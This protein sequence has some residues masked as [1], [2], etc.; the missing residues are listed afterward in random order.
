M[1]E[2]LYEEH[3]ADDTPLEINVPKSLLS[4]ARSE[5]SYMIDA[6]EFD[7]VRR[8]GG[9]DANDS[10]RSSSTTFNIHIY[11]YA[12]INPLLTVQN[13]LFD[14]MYQDC[15]VRFV[16]AQLMS[17]TQLTLRMSPKLVKSF[18]G[19]ADCYCLSDPTLRDNPVVFASDGFVSVTG[20]SR[21]EIIPYNCR[22]LQGENTDRETVARIKKACDKNEEIVEL[23]LNYRKDKTPFWN[24]LFIDGK[25]RYFLGAQVD[26]TSHIAS[27]LACTAF[28]D[29]FADSTTTPSPLQ[30]APST[31][32]TFSPT[33]AT[34]LTS[35]SPRSAI[36]PVAGSGGPGG[37]CGG[38]DVV[39]KMK[40]FL[41]K[42]MGSSGSFTNI[43]EKDAGAAEPTEVKSAKKDVRDRSHP[44]FQ[45]FSKYLILDPKNSTI[46]FAS[47]QLVESLKIPH[48]NHSHHIINRDFTSYLIGP[49][50]KS[51]TRD[52]V[53][54][55]LR[56]GRAVAETIVSNGEVTGGTPMA[57]RIHITP[58]KDANNKV[59]FFVVVMAVD[60][61]GTKILKRYGSL[62]YEKQTL[63]DDRPWS[64]AE[65][66][67]VWTKEYDRS[68]ERTGSS[69]GSGFLG[70]L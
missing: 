29:V 28:S 11:H 45:T 26:V 6:L 51:S 33:S 30:K 61:E 9:D 21:E 24:L 53:C 35:E 43:I 1:Y 15:F 70:N 55:A 67:A 37:N 19:L 12:G 25:V 27:E 16:K 40:R 7:K 56:E 36:A 46:L 20:Y 69:L 65:I 39:R 63:D 14:F 59:G 54:S 60:E 18:L 57:I 8:G 13:E 17:S 22:F 2:D 44:F 3:I 64:T 42:T 38:G 50:S 58:M 48:S 68:A 52:A 34:T 10:K 4:N 31:I 49:L 41:G 5:I 23:L 62:G 47:K 66:R 32:Y